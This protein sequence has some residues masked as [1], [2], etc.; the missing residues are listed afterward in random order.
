MKKNYNYN[1]MQ[2][3]SCPM[4]QNKFDLKFRLPLILDCSYGHII[5][6]ADIMENFIP[7]KGFKCPLCD[8]WSDKSLKQLK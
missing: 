2:A 8:E 4:C 3:L 5:C 6:K 7:G 1:K